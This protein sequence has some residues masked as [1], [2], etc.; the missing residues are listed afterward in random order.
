[1]PFAKTLR[2]ALLI[3]ALGSTACKETENTETASAKAFESLSTEDMQKASV[4]SAVDAISEAAFEMDS[5]IDSK[6]MNL[7]EKNLCRS[8][9]I[10]V[11][12]F[13]EQER[14]SQEEF[15][16]ITITTLVHSTMTETKCIELII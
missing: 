4:D 7:T 10:L 14:Y 15:D 1:M 5:Q 3:A 8:K 2:C 9:S 16:C 13:R 6:P 12:S 11:A